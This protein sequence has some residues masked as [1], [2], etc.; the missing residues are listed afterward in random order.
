MT[1]HG[2]V[3]IH[4]P[5][6][7]DDV[8]ST[9]ATST[10]PPRG[11]QARRGRHARRSRR[12]GAAGFGGSRLRLPRAGRRGA[13]SGVRLRPMARHRRRPARTRPDRR[14]GGDPVAID[15]IVGA[16]R[17]GPTSANSIAILT[18]TASHS[19]R[20][21]ATPSTAAASRDRRSDIRSPSRPR[22]DGPGRSVRS[23]VA[24]DVNS[25][26][27]VDDVGRDDGRGDRQ[28]C[29]PSDRAGHDDAGGRPAHPLRAR[30]TARRHRQ[31]RPRWRAGR[32]DRRPDQPAGSGVARR[33]QH[34]AR[35]DADPGVARRGRHRPVAVVDA[36]VQAAQLASDHGRILDS[37]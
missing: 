29:R 37:T 32:R 31:R 34:D 35:R 3:V 25:A 6:V 14:S 15:E 4:A 22:A 20:A 36:I 5:A 8:D 7:A 1:I 16:G 21:E 10:T 9:A 11:D 13:G 2:I 33:R 27:D 12:S 17:I 18:P 26:A 19:P 24:L 23:G 30:R 28:R